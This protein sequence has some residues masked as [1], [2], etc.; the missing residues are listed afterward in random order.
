MNG[1]LVKTISAAGAVGLVFIMAFLMWSQGN[2]DSET[3]N[4]HINDN[5]KVMSAVVEVIRTQTNTLDRIEVSLD[6]NTKA[7]ERLNYILA[8]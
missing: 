7:T 5:T 8:E 6:N 1:T 2:R 3:I 4:N